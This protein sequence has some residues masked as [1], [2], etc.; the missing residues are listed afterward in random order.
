MQVLTRHEE[1]L[2]NTLQSEYWSGL[3]VEAAEV[4]D[5]EFNIFSSYYTFKQTVED[6][7]FNKYINCL[8]VYLYSEKGEVFIYELKD[9]PFIYLV[10]ILPREYRESKRF[11]LEAVKLYYYV[12]EEEP[13]KEFLGYVSVYSDSF[14]GVLSRE[15]ASE[16]VESLVKKLWRLRLL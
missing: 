6:V 11:N 13:D 8:E 9:E 4:E 3:F 12:G 10:E 5:V 16:L 1:A 2:R 15:R 7:R 14:I